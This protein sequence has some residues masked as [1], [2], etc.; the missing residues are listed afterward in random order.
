MATA[1]RV[2]AASHG[3]GSKLALGVLALGAFVIGTAELVVIGILNLVAKDQGVSVSTAGQLVTAYALGIA[4]GAPILSALTGR[5][6]RRL[7]LRVS[8]AAFVVGNL[9]AVA[10]A[11]FQMLLVARV[12]TGAIHG[13]FIGVASVLAAGLVTPERRGQAISMVFGGIA[14]STVVGVPAGTLIGQTLGWRAAFAV[15]AVLGV[16]ALVASLLFVPSVAGQGSGR[17]RSQAHAAFAPRVLGMLGVG[18]LLMGAQFT[19]FTYLTPF[20]GKVTGVSGGLVSVFLLVFGIAA[21]AGTLLGG[22]AADHSATTTLLVA[23]VALVGALGALYFVGATP[24][25]VLVALAAWGL[26]GF[27]MIPAL[28]LRVISL[29][30]TGAD[31][32]ATLGASAVNGG[33]AAGSLVGGAVLIRNGA[34]APLLVATVLAA[35]AIPVTWA[36]RFLT[37]PDKDPDPSV[38]GPRRTGRR[39][40]QLALIKA[41]AARSA[42][43][44][45][46]PAA[47][48]S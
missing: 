21:A 35:V 12:L 47:K 39:T 22:R 7:V 1:V 30:G 33:I 48:A 6:G 20:L 38:V 17:L 8:L 36:T 23:N 4:L 14:V 32:A 31:L 24:V 37:P 43:A 9:L 2:P 10:A 26:S 45:A 25:L 27:A 44:G 5:F 28:Q 18:F 19:A 40:P 16:V 13:L 11:S 15:I 41:P 3:G 29:A 42:V 34:S 46:Q